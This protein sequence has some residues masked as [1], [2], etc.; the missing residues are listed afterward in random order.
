MG[1]LPISPW[2]NHL[3]DEQAVRLSVVVDVDHGPRS[4]SHSALGLEWPVD[5]ANGGM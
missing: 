5:E 4:V 1:D 3:H 2:R